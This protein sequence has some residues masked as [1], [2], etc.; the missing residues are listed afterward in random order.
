MPGARLLDSSVHAV[1]TCLAT[2]A[3][4]WASRA[5]IFR[6]VHYVGLRARVNKTPNVNC[7]CAEVPPRE[8]ETACALNIIA[9]ESATA[10][11]N[12]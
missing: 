2:E 8:P 1:A 5:L 4:R 7:I 12:I 3:K 9:A 6:V 11:A 10:T